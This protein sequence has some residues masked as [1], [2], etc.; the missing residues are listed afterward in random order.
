M[1]SHGSLQT[2]LSKRPHVQRCRPPGRREEEE[3]VEGARLPR[4]SVPWRLVSGVPAWMSTC[5]G[6]E[7]LFPV[8]L[9]VRTILVPT[10]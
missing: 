6:M 10:R 2:R 3:C 7:A 5:F 8:R 1:A 9:S 4:E